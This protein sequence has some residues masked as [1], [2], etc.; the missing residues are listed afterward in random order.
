MLSVNV[1]ER[2]SSTVF[3]TLERGSSVRV[4]ERSFGQFGK[5]NAR[6][7]ALMKSNE[8]TSALHDD[9]ASLS[10]HWIFYSEKKRKQ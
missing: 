5:S 6:R 9:I 1:E 10:I 2:F 4:S 7:S 3:A 8:S